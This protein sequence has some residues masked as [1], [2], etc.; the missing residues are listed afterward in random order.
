LSNP[1]T[2]QAVFLAKLSG[3]NGSALWATQSTGSG[4]D[5][6]PIAVAV[7]KND[8]VALTGVF[9]RGVTF[10][11]TTLT[12]LD[13]QDM[14]VAKFSGAGSLQWASHFGGST[15]SDLASSN[16]ITTDGSGN[17]ILTGFFLGT[18]NLNGTSVT[19]ASSYDAFM[20]KL[21]P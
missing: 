17:I 12:S 14:F 1:T 9:P 21:N 3:A 10:G 5:A 15:Q 13:I 7:D 2:K 8:N 4:G 16:A 18:V 11:S 20:L 6:N 19:S